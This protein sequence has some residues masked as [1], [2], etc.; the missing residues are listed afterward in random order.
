MRAGYSWSVMRDRPYFLW[1]VNVTEAELR[2]RLRHPDPRIRAQWQGVTM[3]E[4]AYRDVWRYVSVEDIV[5]DWDWIKK[6]L[7]RERNFWEFLLSG[8]RSLGLIKS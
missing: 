7:G 2:D 5:R 1:D 8:W 6:H 3:R 4:A